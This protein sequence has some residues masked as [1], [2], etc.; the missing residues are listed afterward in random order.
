MENFFKERTEAV[1]NSISSKYFKILVVVSIALVAIILVI[2]FFGWRK[3]AN[4]CVGFL[5]FISMDILAEFFAR[6]RVNFIIAIILGGI[7]GFILDVLLF[8]YVACITGD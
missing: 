6:H 4:G 5:S 7:I 2:P 3:V 8:F 1:G